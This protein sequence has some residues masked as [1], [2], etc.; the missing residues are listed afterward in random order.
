[1]E[2][3]FVPGVIAL[4]GAFMIMIIILAV[5]ALIVVKALTDSPWGTFTVMATIPIAIFMG[6]YTRFIR[7]GKIGEVSIIGFFLLMLAIIGGGWVAGSGI[8][9]YFHYRGK[10]GG[11]ALAWILIGYGFVA[12]VL[13]V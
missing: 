7:P 6:L 9:Q 4:F 2:L 1:M 10:E 11:I 8:G 13:P 3:G 5:L 12:S